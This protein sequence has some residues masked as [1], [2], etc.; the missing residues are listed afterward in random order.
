MTDNL[1]GAVLMSLAMAG[2]ALEDMFIKLL[3]DTL[4]V[5][6]ILVL[7]GAGGH[8]HLA[9]SPIAKGNKCFRPHCLHLRCCCAMPLK[10]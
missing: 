5:G 4:P 8:S 2:F 3:A 9:Q 1:R 10:L 6:Q 7:L